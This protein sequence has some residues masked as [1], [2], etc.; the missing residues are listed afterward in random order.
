MVGLVGI[1]F[2]EKTFKNKINLNVD[3]QTITFILL[4]ILFLPV[5]NSRTLLIHNNENLCSSRNISNNQ[6]SI[7]IV[8]LSSRKNF[9]QRNLIRQTYGSIRQFNHVHI[10]AVVF[11]LGSLDSPYR[12]TVDA[13]ELY[14]ESV[15]YGDI[16]MGDFVDTYRNLSRKSIM[17]YDWLVSYC[18][19]ADILVKTDDDVLVNIFTLTKELTTW[20]S[21]LVRS[22]SF[23]CFVHSLETFDRN[24]SSFYYVSREEYP[25]DKVPKH[26]A[27]LGYITPMAMV[28]RIAKE[29]SKSFP[30]KICP[31]EDVFMTGIVPERIISDTNEEIQ[32]IDR[33][34]EWI[35]YILDNLD[36]ETEAKVYL[37]K[38]IERPDKTKIDCVEFRQWFDTRLFYLIDH[39]DN[40]EKIY[41]NVWHLIEMCY[42][43]EMR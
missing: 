30:D 1:M 41:R 11:M 4:C 24:E 10:L 16:I 5:R 40:F 28:R 35:F 23:W 33:V 9:A 29:I 37:L 26:C 17:A 43:S 2:T 15:Q 6:Y 39:G 14:S 42:N 38:L 19:A 32:Y 21:H 31:Q 13:N 3:F 8:V 7:V 27:G 25:Y 34:A 12:E 20:S 18:Q 36:Y 22:Y